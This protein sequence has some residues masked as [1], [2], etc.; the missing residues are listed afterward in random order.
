MVDVTPSSAAAEI[1]EDGQCEGVASWDNTSDSPFLPL[2]ASH[3][4]GIESRTTASSLLPRERI[5]FICLG[6]LL[7]LSCLVLYVLHTRYHFPPQH[8]D[9]HVEI[10]SEQHGEKKMFFLL[11]VSVVQI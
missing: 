4:C 1:T 5:G 3:F 8:I 7:N 6:S 10:N 2:N 9:L 11:P